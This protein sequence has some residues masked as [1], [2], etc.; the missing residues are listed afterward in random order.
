MSGHDREEILLG[1]L[2]IMGRK[3]IGQYTK[4]NMDIE[5]KWE[6]WAGIVR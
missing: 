3:E 6:S 2:E 4:E 5:E 1:D